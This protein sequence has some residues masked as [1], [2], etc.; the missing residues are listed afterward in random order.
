MTFDQRT[1]TNLHLAYPFIGW[2]RRLTLVLLLVADHTTS[3]L[4]VY[5]LIM[6]FFLIYL[7]YVGPYLLSR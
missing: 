2:M 6:L 5:R 3:Q 1:R 4:L 7:G